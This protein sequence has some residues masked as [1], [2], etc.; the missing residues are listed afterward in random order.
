MAQIFLSDSSRRNQ[1][2]SDAD[3]EERWNQA[4]GDKKRQTCSD[5]GEPAAETKNGLCRKCQAKASSI[6]VESY[7]C[8]KCQNIV[9]R[10]NEF[11]LCSICNMIENS[12]ERERYNGE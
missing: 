9:L 3:M 4:F 7:T 5:C 10:V 2:I 11:G 1:Q 8:V 12:E 6:T